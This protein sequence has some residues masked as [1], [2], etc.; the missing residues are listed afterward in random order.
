MMK[1]TGY[2]NTIAEFNLKKTWFIVVLL[3]EVMF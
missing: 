2:I 1:V 3:I